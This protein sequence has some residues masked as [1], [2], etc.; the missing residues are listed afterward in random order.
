ML[1]MIFV[2][3]LDPKIWTVDSEIMMFELE[4]WIFD[5]TT[6]IF[7]PKVMLLDPI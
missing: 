7:A 4:I 6:H 5:L 2:P 1:T 3:N